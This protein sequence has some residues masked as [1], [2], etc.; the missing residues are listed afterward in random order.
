MTWLLRNRIAL[1]ALVVLVPL[2]VFATAGLEIISQGVVQPTPTPVANK[3]PFTYLGATWKVRG[4]REFDGTDANGIPKGSALVAALVDVTPVAGSR[5][6]KITGCTMTLDAPGPSGTRT[7][8][9]LLDPEDYHYVRADGTVSGCDMH[10][11]KPETIEVVFLTPV[12]TIDRAGIVV[13]HSD[14]KR[15][16]RFRLALHDD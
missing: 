12:D 3:K 2:V 13:E 5:A 10:P 7:W 4:S 14:G 8:D 11:A 16:T 9:A 6:P 1:L 15:L